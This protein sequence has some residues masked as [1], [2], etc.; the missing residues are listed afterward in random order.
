M[1]D[2]YYLINSYFNRPTFRKNLCCAIHL[3]VSRKQRHFLECIV[4]GSK[5]AQKVF[6]VQNEHEN[7]AGK[8]VKELALTPIV[9]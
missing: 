2:R 9:I 6:E 4:R 3:I 5:R 8:T 1:N 7:I